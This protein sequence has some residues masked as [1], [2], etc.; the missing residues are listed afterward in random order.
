[1]S[2]DSVIG[3]PFCSLTRRPISWARASSSAASRS[4]AAARWARSHCDQPDGSSNARRAAAT[5]ASTSASAASGAS[6]MGSSV[7]ALR[8]AILAAE[9]GDTHSP[10]M[11][12][13]S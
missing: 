4:I 10:P 1:M 13:L 2:G 9:L 11:N 5:A 6:P 12:S 8:T 3:M 7:L